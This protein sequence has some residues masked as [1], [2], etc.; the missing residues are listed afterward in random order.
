MRKYSDWFYFQE[1][2][3]WNYWLQAAFIF[4]SVELGGVVSRTAMPMELLVKLVDSIWK[5]Q[6]GGL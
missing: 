5:I 6:D 2:F 1:K 3:H 4:V